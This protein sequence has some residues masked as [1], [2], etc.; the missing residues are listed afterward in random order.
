MARISN[1]VVE[2]RDALAPPS[3]L[4]HPE[5]EVEYAVCFSL[6]P[7]LT[8]GSSTAFLPVADGTQQP[9]PGIIDLPAPPSGA[10]LAYSLNRK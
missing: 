4:V 5:G 10:A 6:T 8:S 2:R 7:A 9:F 1:I 3:Q